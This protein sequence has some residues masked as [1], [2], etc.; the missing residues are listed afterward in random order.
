[1]TLYDIQVQSRKNA[2]LEFECPP[3]LHEGLNRHQM[4]CE[5]CPAHIKKLCM[6]AVKKGM[7]KK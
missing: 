7:G 4:T 3:I 5:N 2:G 6:E 1:M